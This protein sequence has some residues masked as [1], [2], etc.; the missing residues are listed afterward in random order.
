MHVIFKCHN[1]FDRIIVNNLMNCYHI[2]AV[3]IFYACNIQ[4]PQQFCLKD[5]IFRMKGN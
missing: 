1:S 4:M 5:S 3:W 2:I